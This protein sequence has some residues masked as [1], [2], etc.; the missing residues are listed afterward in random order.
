M[1]GVVDGERGAGERSGGRGAARRSAAETAAAGLL[2]AACSS[3]RPADGAEAARPPLAAG[4]RGPCRRSRNA[5]V[6]SFFCIVFS[7]FFAESVTKTKKAV[8]ILTKIGALA[9][10]QRVRVSTSLTPHGWGSCSALG[11]SCY[12]AGPAAAGFIPGHCCMLAG[13]A[14]GWAAGRSGPA[15]AGSSLAVV[16]GGPS[17]MPHPGARART[18]GRSHAARV[19]IPSF[20]RCLAPLTAGLAQ[21][22]PRQGQAAQPALRGAPRPA[23]GDQRRAGGR[24]RVP[25]R[26][27]RRGGVRGPPQPAA[28]GA[29][30]PPRPVCDLDQ[31]GAAEAGRHLR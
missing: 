11:C 4:G 16:G 22:P 3:C 8:E 20:P 1:L 26:P 5:A 15:G 14:A 29:G 30:R 17:G 19:L 6:R 31:A 23:A 21:H 13:W 27:R 25:Q 9:D 2:S 12:S 24:A 10:V 28:A 18:V 7:P